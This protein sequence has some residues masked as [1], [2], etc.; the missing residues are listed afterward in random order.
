MQYLCCVTKPV[1]TIECEELHSSAHKWRNERVPFGTQ[2]T[3]VRR[4][5]FAKGGLGFGED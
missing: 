2:I 4:S 1:Y 3:V 5:A